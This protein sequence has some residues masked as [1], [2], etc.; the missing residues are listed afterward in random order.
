MI[1]IKKTLTEHAATLPNFWKCHKLYFV[2]K[3]CLKQNNCFHSLTDLVA[4][5]YNTYPSSRL[6]LLSTTVPQHCE[7]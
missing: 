6:H 7:Q 3:F 5:I 2:S 4:I 1:K